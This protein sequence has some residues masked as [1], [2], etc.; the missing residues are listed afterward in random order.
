[1]ACFGNEHLG[2]GRGDLRRGSPCVCVCVCLCTCV[3]VCVCVC[4]RLCASIES[5]SSATVYCL[6]SSLCGAFLLHCALTSVF[7]RV[8]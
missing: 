6:P 5:S 7:V 2:D 3:Y 1:M 4:V 8:L